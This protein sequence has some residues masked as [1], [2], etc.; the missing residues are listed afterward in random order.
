MTQI[1][2]DIGATQF[3]K[4]SSMWEVGQRL[5][6]WLAFPLYCCI[7]SSEFLYLWAGNPG[8]STTCES[9]ILWLEGRI[10]QITDSHSIYWINWITGLSECSWLGLDYWVHRGSSLSTLSELELEPGQSPKEKWDTLTKS[11]TND[12]LCDNIK[13]MKKA[14]VV[15]NY[16]YYI[17]GST[18]LW[19]FRFKVGLHKPVISPI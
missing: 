3:H 16:L 1:H 11:S 14:V 19:W 12:I 7:M 4:A 15:N 17:K 6:H 13:M 8:S 9:V 10:N 5:P 2:R 18:E